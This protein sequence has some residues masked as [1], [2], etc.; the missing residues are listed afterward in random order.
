MALKYRSE[1]GR[2]LTSA[3]VD[4]NFRQLSMAGTVTRLTFVYPAG[5]TTARVIPI[6]F[7]DQ[8]GTYQIESE[9]NVVG[10]KY[11]YVNGQGRILPITLALG[12]SLSVQATTP[13]GLIGN[14]I[15][16]RQ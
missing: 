13:A 9:A 11:F 6:N 14:I 10:D 5:Q 8:P 3:E 1:L 2:K 16:R 7:P 12:D 15:L 4:D